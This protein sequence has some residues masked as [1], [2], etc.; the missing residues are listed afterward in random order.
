MFRVAIAV[1]DTYPSSL[2]F[3]ASLPPSSSH[4]VPGRPTSNVRDPH[5]RL[6]CCQGAC[7]GQRPPGIHWSSSDTNSFS[8]GLRTTVGRDEPGW[9]RTG[10]ARLLARGVLVTHPARPWRLK[11]S[12][13]M[14][15]NVGIPHVVTRL[16]LKIKPEGQ[17]AGFGPCF[18]LPRFHFGAGFLSHSHMYIV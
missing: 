12:C 5:M 11:S 13:T 17:T 9:H 10:R 15:L 14:L 16:W 2:L 1:F 6:P 3:Q 7:P 8:E 4:W 18:H